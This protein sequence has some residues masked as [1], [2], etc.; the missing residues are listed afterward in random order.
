[1][2]QTAFNVPF[3][4]NASAPAPAEI[5]LYVSTD[6]GGSW[7]LYDRATP[8]AKQFAFRATADGEYWFALRTVAADGRANP[9]GPTYKPGVRV[10]V[11]TVEPQLEFEAT[12]GAAGEIKTSWKISDPTLAPET[13]K[14]EY[15]PTLGG[16]WQPIAIDRRMDANAAGG[17]AGQTTWWPETSSRVI[18]VR[19]E[20]SDRASNRSVVNRR[21]FLPKVA[22]SD[23]TNSHSNTAATAPPNG[24]ASREQEAGIAWLPTTTPG[25]AGTWQPPASGSSQWLAATGRDRTE[26]PSQNASAPNA[27]GI[28]HGTTPK[29][30]ANSFLT[31]T[32]PLSDLGAYPAVP[33]KTQPPVTRQVTDGNNQQ[34]TS[35]AAPETRA[36]PSG[37]RPRMTNVLKFELEYD[38][39]AVGPA[40]V[41]EVQLW[42]TSDNGQTWTQWQTDTDKQSPLEISV[43]RDGVYG[44]RVVVIGANGLSGPVP[45]NGDLADLWVG[46]DTVVPRTRLTSAIYGEGQQAG[47]LDIRWEASDTSLGERPVT[48]QFAEAGTG[49]WSTVASGLPNTGQYYWPVDGRIPEKIYLRIEVRDEAGNVGEFQLEE[50]VSTSGLVP[51]AHIRGLRSATSLF[52]DSPLRRLP[53]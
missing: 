6:R 4:I 42:G 10:I 38:V 3:T 13:L 51:Q 24:P 46:V 53:R 1:M 33:G 50:P 22:G 40:G 30:S 43:P 17:I 29:S 12:V 20:I 36:L 21:L 2:R 7:K 16:P 27:A 23:E 37:E 15:Q 45:H 28:P 19:G 11:D 35:P 5:Q 39:E 26:S 8:T 14:I 18:H 41:A 34:P 9:P 32:Q 31:A 48:L 49:P 47:Q 44:F 25:A 52:I